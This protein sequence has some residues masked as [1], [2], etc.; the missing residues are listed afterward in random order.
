METIF[1]ILAHFLPAKE[2]QLV[3]TT[4]DPMNLTIVHQG[5]IFLA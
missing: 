3:T 2:V 1:I 5:L 4:E